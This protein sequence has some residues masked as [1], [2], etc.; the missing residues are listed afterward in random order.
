MLDLSAGW[1][2]IAAATVI[3]V[4]SGPAAAV[5][6]LDTVLAAITP[7]S[8]VVNY[9][10]P[11][12]PTFVMTVTEANTA[13]MTGSD[14]FDYEGLW[15]GSDGTGGRYTFSFN[16]PVSS[17]SLTFIALTT[18]GG[19]F[20]E[21]LNTFVSSTPTSAG[22]ISA[23]ASASWSGSVVTPLQ[24]DSRGVI[25]FTATGLPFS[26]IRFDHAQA[27]DLQGFIVERIDAAP[28]PV[29]E[30][31]TALMW[32]VGLLSLWGLRRLRDHDR[33]GT[34]P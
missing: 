31:V 16:Q 32:C 30:P 1:R 6:F 29:P 21:T 8:G 15:L 9:S 18:L 34:M 25:T 28:A 22:F 19:G 4:S 12:A 26:S 5:T 10:V 3:A 17:F 24:E 20:L 11:A 13:T 2:A 23:D 27:F 33:E 7:N 14:L